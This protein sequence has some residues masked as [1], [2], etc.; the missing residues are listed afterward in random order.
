MNVETLKREFVYN[1]VKLPDP[2]PQMSI[3]QVRETYAAAYP[4]IN[5][6]A[7]EGPETAGNKMIYRFVR[8]IGVKG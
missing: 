1:G 5:T 7:V 2:N 4:E 3:E 6:A 8:A